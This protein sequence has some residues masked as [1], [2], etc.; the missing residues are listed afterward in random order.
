MDDQ[1]DN[2]VPAV[3]PKPKVKKKLFTEKMY[4]DRAMFVI[5]DFVNNEETKFRGSDY[6]KALNDLQKYFLV[7]K[8][9][10]SIDSYKVEY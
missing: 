3:P 8:P 5:N 2:V 1:I 9:I 7:D 4:Y 10:A 6:V